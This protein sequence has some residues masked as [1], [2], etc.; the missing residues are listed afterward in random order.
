MSQENVDV[1]ER[2]IAAVNAR[3]LDAYL[4]C[5]TDDIQLSVSTPSLRD[6][7]EGRDGIRRFFNDLGDTTPDFELAVERLEIVGGDRVLIFMRATGTGRVS[8]VP[9]EATTGN[10]Y[11]LI[12]GKIKRVRIFFDRHEALEAVGLRE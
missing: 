3:D 4:S 9:T 10:V 8:R 2:A 1:V 7:Y 11:D 5:C 6:A 12:D